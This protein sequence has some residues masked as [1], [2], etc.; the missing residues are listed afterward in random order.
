MAYVLPRVFIVLI[1]WGIPC[2]LISN[3]W[4]RV[5]A[6]TFVIAG[7]S[8]ALAGLVGFGYMHKLR[9]DAEDQQSRF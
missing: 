9:V 3:L 7:A 6:T 1:G 8:W 4:P 2:A 5:D